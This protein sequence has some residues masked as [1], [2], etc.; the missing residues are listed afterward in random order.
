MNKTNGTKNKT[1]I[2]VVCIHSLHV[3]HSSKA[4]DQTERMAEDIIVIESA[5]T[6]VVNVLL[7]Q[8]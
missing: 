8:G 3:H 4:L 5:Q 2:L 1:K 6:A 7:H